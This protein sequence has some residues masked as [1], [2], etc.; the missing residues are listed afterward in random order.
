M[1]GEQQQQQ[2]QQS[3]EPSQ[4]A[5]VAAAG[6]FKDVVGNL[7]KERK[8]WTELL[9]RTAFS[10]PEN[11]AEA[12]GRLKKNGAYFRVNYLAFM[13]VVTVTCMVLNPTSLVVLGCL[14]L[15][16]AYFFGI[17]KDPLVIGGR[18]FSEREK[19]LGLTVTSA[20]MIFFVTS[21]GTI[22]FTALGISVAVIGLHGAC[23]VPDDLFTDEVEQ[24]SGLLGFFTA[25]TSAA[26]Q[27]A[28]AV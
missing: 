12:T 26:S 16:W 21:V 8:P 6:R 14:A 20:I 28:N 19:F 1:S 15:L 11:F 5:I 27:L 4:N 25:P 17:R 18:S 23:R 3:A 13:L 22:L 9:D 2:Q 7:L 24:Q 10:R